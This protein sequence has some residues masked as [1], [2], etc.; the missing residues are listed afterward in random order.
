MLAA[1]REHHSR[2]INLGKNWKAANLDQ[3]IQSIKEK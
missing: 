2:I 1:R 3:R